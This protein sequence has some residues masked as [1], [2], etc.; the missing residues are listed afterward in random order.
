MIRPPR[1]GVCVCVWARSRARSSALSTPR[2]PARRGW[3]MQV[4]DTPPHLGVQTHTHTHTHMAITHRSRYTHAPF[5]A[6]I[7]SDAQAR[8]RHHR[9]QIGI[10]H[11][12]RPRVAMVTSLGRATVAWA[13]AGMMPETALLSRTHRRAPP[14]APGCCPGRHLCRAVASD[15]P[16]RA[17][18]SWPRMQGSGTELHTPNSGKSIWGSSGCSWSN[19]P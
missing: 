11:R 2:S 4:Q 17:G 8:H 13:A 9:R 16:C 18:R 3:T 1:E 14:W 7:R 5:R 19:V 12:P 15:S 10:G 6:A